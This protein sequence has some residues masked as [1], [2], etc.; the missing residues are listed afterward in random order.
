MHR[1]L[2]LFV[3]LSLA[4][5]GEEEDGGFLPP[6]GGGS[7]DGGSSGDDGGADDLPEE[8]GYDRD[9]IWVRLDAGYEGLYGVPAAFQCG[10]TGEGLY[11]VEGSVVLDGVDEGY[12]A[13]RLFFPQEPEPG[14]SYTFAAP[15]ELNAVG[16]PSAV[17]EGTVV[18][19]IAEGSGP[20]TETWLGV[21]GSGEL[22]IELLN[23][24]TEPRYRWLEAGL[25][26]AED[27]T[28]ALSEAGHLRCG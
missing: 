28:E 16:T 4:A 1:L 15:E 5:C 17:A 13:A 7:S 11:E 21:A 24:A 27:G 12:R 26:H 6:T 9:G 25:A 20:E 18:L 23:G 22:A 14:D 2:P 8:L 10:T 3:A 19:V